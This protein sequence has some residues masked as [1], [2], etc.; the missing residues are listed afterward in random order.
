MKVEFFKQKELNQNYKNSIIEAIYDLINGRENIVTGNYSKSFEKLFSNYIGSKYC[1]FL[2]NGL[3]ALT[4]ALKTINVKQG[5][6]I[7]VPNHT[8]IAT[9][10]AGLNLGCIIIP[11]PVKENS[12]LI[13]EDVIE[14]FITPQTK[15]IIPVH[16]YGN[17]TN[18]KKIA[19]IA[20]EYKLFII[21]DAAQAH[22][23]IT[24]N[25]KV[26][27]FFDISCFSFYPTK[28]LGALGEAGCI[29]TNNYEFINKINSLKNYG[30][31]SINSSLNSI[32][33]L[34]NRGDEIQAAFLISKLNNLD[35]IIKKRKLI[36]KRYKQLENYNNPDN[37]KLL[38]YKKGSSPHLAVV[39]LKDKKT[40]NVLKD[41]LEDKSIST[42][43]HY[44]IPC[45]KQ[46]FLKNN[47]FRITES[48][49]KQAE[50]IANT[51]LSLPMSE[52][53]NEGEINYVIENINK[54]FEQQK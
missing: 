18:F 52:V 11:V 13:D 37:I 14:N 38:S 12:L 29:T 24:N 51:I 17:P 32:Q 6:E 40:R 53:H 50:N 46:S 25:K 42:M 36:L 48:I 28:N 1:S 21:D 33:G 44:E 7:I 45:H 4:I 19:K 30:R 10:L 20:K 35:N 26:G 22:G 43:I 3:D 34:N 15:A 31:S 39:R 54:F 27:S 2:S 9:W 5:D 23:T 47:Q 16:I 49:A 41:Y 8:Y